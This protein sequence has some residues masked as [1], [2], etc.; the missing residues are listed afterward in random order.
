MSRGG[1]PSR[2]KL[3]DRMHSAALAG[4]AGAVPWLE[5][6]AA[7]MAS[8]NRLGALQ[9]LASV[10]DY[11]PLPHQLRAHLSP[12]RHKLFLGGVGSGKSTWSM[13]EA[14]VLSLLNPPGCTGVVLGPTYDIVTQVL[15]PSW[16]A[17]AESLNAAGIPFLRRYNKSQAK[18]DLEDGSSVLFRSFHKADSIRGLNATFACLDEVAVDSNPNYVWDVIA[19]RLRDPRSN[20]IQLHATT[21]PKGLVNIPALFHRMRET[22]ARPDWW[23]GRAT[24]MDNPHLPPGFID[25]LKQGYSKRQWEQE[26]LGKCLQAQATVWPEIEKERHVIPWTYDPALPYYM[27]MDFGYAKPA[28]LFAQEHRGALIVFWEYV[29][30]EV[31]YE[32]QKSIIRNKIAE[33]GKPPEHVVGD[34]ADREWMSWLI[35]NLAHSQVHRMQ[36]KMDQRVTTGIEVVRSMLDPMIGEPR[37]YVAKSLTENPP[38][39]GIW[40]ALHNYRWKLTKDGLIGD[41]ALKDG[42]F[43]HICDTIRWIS[44]IFNSDTGGPSMLTRGN[45]GNIPNRRNNHRN[46]RRGGR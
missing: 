13:A 45:H 8:Q 37:L 34:R 12:A 26:V 23:V 43:D 39:R 3:G 30:D 38:E 27:G 25:S 33:L 9:L 20:V 24:S 4:E 31:P 22:E 2:A 5:V 15:L 10:S 17:F 6:K 18:A 1:S 7:L 11:D 46:G 36:T 29:E 28:I 44:I 41:S 14:V 40:R 19:G 21:T 42:T 35:Q 16:L 32:K